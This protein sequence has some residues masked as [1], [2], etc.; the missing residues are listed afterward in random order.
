MATLGGACKAPSIHGFTY[1]SRC[2]GPKQA[3]MSQ[4]LRPVAEERRTAE[5]RLYSAKLTELSTMGAWGVTCMSPPGLGC[6]KPL[7]QKRPIA[8]AA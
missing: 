6:A 2:F 7:W 4:L 5:D 8:P 3:T 1:P